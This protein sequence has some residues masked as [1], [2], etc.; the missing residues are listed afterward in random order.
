VRIFILLG[1][2]LCTGTTLA[3]ER[4]VER[5]IPVDADV[6]FSLDSHR[7]GVEIVTGAVDSVEIFVSIRHDDEDVLDEVNIDIDSSRSRVS[8]KTDYVPSPVP[9]RF[10]GFNDFSNS[11]VYP[12]IR[13]RIVVPE[14]A[15]LRIKGHRSDLDI[16]APSGTVV[17]SSHRGD[18]R[19]TNVRN[20]LEIDTHR[21]NFDVEVTE[22]H[23]IDLQSHR[24]DFRLDVSDADDF[25]LS[26]ETHRGNL[27][28]IGKDIDVSRRD[29]DN[30]V[31]HREG[32]GSNQISFNTH[33][34][35][36]RMNFD[37]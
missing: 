4:I 29:R 11:F 28:F 34:G 37:D 21:G 14:G 26:G 17:V 8:V 10:F 18:G 24:G 6:R 7:G 20:D 31:T 15:S 12:D 25:M 22:L 19:I 16:A 23:D 27:R 33:R 3:A 2:L 32:N 5:S 1:S 36:I 9:F 13:Y 35:N 30:R